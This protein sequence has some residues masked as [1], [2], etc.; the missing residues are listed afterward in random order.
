MVCLARRLLADYDTCALRLSSAPPPLRPGSDE[1]GFFS[2]KMNG[3]YRELQDFIRCLGVP[4]HDNVFAFFRTAPCPVRHTDPGRAL[5]PCDARYCDGRRSAI[6]MLDA[7]AGNLAHAPAGLARDGARRGRRPHRSAR[8]R[9]CA[10]FRARSAAERRGRNDERRAQQ[11]EYD[12]DRRRRARDRWLR[13]RHRPG[14]PRGGL[15]FGRG[16]FAR[17]APGYGGARSHRD[18]AQRRAR[19]GVHER[20]RRSRPGGCCRTAASDRPAGRDR[21][22]TRRPAAIAAAARQAG[23]P[24]PGLDRAQPRRRIPGAPGPSGEPV[25]EARPAPGRRDQERQRPAAHEHGRRDASLPA[26]RHRPAGARGRAAPGPQRDA[27]L[28]YALTGAPRNFLPTLMRKTPID[29]RILCVALA[30][31]AH[32]ASGQTPEVP[33]APP[34]APGAPTVTPGAATVT[35]GAATVTPGAPPVQSPA[36]AARTPGASA[37]AVNPR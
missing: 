28:R 27:V 8:A 7:G 6:A 2:C 20:S 32:T 29:A 22:A 14:T 36:P 13:A 23:I 11:P 4:T 33:G 31:A 25:R 16:G 26:V 30:L 34:V 37:I 12:S 1:K 21:P 15:L 3:L 5:A 17:R 18:R 35:P 24:Q 10:A 19:S 9:Q